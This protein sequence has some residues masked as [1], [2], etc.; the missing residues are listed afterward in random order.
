MNDL[1]GLATSAAPVFGTLGLITIGRFL[2]RAQAIG[3]FLRLSGLFVILLGVLAVT[4][5]VDIHG[6]RL[7]DLG[8]FAADVAEWAYRTLAPGGVF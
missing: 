3:N 4:G 2:L 8:A 6:A 7:L 5:V 1:L